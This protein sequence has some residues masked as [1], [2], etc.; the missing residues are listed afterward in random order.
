MV[1]DTWAVALENI[2]QGHLKNK[3]IIDLSLS[4]TN[5]PSRKEKTI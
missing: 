1:G 4:R 3:I 5:I 2:L